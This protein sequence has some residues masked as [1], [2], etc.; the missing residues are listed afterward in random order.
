[1]ERIARRVSRAGRRPVVFA[2]LLLVALTVLAVPA[3][4]RER[5]GR[6]AL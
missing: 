2:A 4:G 5:Q 1:M 3:A 6:R